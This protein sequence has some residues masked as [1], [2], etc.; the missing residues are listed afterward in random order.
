MELLTFTIAAGETKRF[1]R[2]GRY[3]EIIDATA[4]ISVV[5]DGEVG[6]RQDDM[7]GALSGFY[8][9]GAFKSFAVSS[10]TAQAVTIMFAEGSGGS[11]RQ[12]GNVTIIDKVG[13][14]TITNNASDIATLGLVVTALVAPAA[15]VNGII[16]RA[17]LV[18]SQGAAS[19]CNVRMIAAPVAPLAQ[20]PTG[21]QSIILA[22]G[23]SPSGAA[24]VTTVYQFD[25]RRQVPPG[26]GL[27]YTRLA[28]AAPTFASLT[29]N[30]EIL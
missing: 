5:F 28:A 29:V 17:S 2:A 8:V 18:E 20:T 11:R 15:N 3:F 9:V 30:Y 4:A 13:A 14:G 21:L 26:W 27:Y 6:S 25:Q 24:N 23:F 1:E 16:V 10:T 19:T 7:I 22:S 12:P